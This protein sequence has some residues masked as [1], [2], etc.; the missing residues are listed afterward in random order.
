MIKAIILFMNLFSLNSF[1]FQQL[2]S[3]QPIP[4]GF[5]SF[6]CNQIQDKELKTYCN[7]ASTDVQLKKAVDVWRHHCLLKSDD[8]GGLPDILGCAVEGK[9][10]LDSLSA[11]YEGSK[12]CLANSSTTDRG[13]VGRSGGGV[14]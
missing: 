8:K 13:N 9:S 5:K 3:P 10:L 14:R 4:T 2:G 6:Y 11:F 12:S 1:A 7:Q